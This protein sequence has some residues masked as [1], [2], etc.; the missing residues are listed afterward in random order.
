MKTV[1]VIVSSF[2]CQFKSAI[3]A[4][5]KDHRVIGICNAVTRSETGLRWTPNIQLMKDLPF[6]AKNP[7]VSA[8]EF[9]SALVLLRNQGMHPDLILLHIGFGFERVCRYMF[10]NTPIVGYCEWFFEQ[11][12]LD[13]YSALNCA[14]LLR[15]NGILKQIDDCSVC[16]TP[17]HSQKMAFPVEKRHRILL[18][19]EGVDI[20]YFVP[21][22][23]KH[24]THPSQQTITYISRGLEHMRKF[25][26][27][28][29]IIKIVLEQNSEVCVKIIGEDTTVYDAVTAHYQADAMIE[30][31]PE[32]LKRV[33]FMGRVSSEQIRNTL[34]TSSIH[35]YLTDVYVTSWSLL[36]A[37]ACGCIVVGS[38]NR[39]LQEFIEDKKTGYLIDHNNSK[40]AANIICNA[41][42]MDAQTSSM[43]RN[44]A[45]ALVVNKYSSKE[46]ATKWGHL[47]NSLL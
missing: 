22:V 13:T 10:P 28:I 7:E 3:N 42:A 11:A 19:H 24:S 37:L 43:M 36:E 32:L 9:T 41:L 21:D 15:N 40:N 20:N 35:V 18:L 1:F 33:H 12:N 6:D 17:T 14:L 44:A 47:L 29:S 8:V 38:D 25:F 31:G 30:L 27:F 2:P 39:V 5:S 16:V 34:Q 26:E 45:R 23:S 46:S 4:I